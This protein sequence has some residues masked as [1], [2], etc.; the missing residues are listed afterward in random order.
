MIPEQSVV[1]SGEMK[2]RVPS[3]KVLLTCV[4]KSEIKLVLESRAKWK[5]SLVIRN[6]VVVSPTIASSIAGLD[7]S[8]SALTILSEVITTIRDLKLISTNKIGKVP[9]LINQLIAFLIT[10]AVDK[11]EDDNGKRMAIHTT[12]DK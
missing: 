11:M 5:E 8:T 4:N 3:F 10:R 2:V 12:F 1:P 9:E 7:R 6:F